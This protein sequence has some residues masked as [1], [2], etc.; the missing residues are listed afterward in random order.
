MSKKFILQKFDC[1]ITEY[2]ISA[3][4]EE[5]ARQKYEEGDFIE[6]DEYYLDGHETLA[7]LILTET[8]KKKLHQ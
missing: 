4:S 5:E 8:D 7:E 3:E 6:I 2:E 1:Y